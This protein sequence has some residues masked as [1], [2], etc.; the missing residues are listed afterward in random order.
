MIGRERHRSEALVIPAQQMFC[1]RA[2]PLYHQHSCS[3]GGVETMPPASRLRDRERTLVVAA[4]DMTVRSHLRSHLY[5]RT[6]FTLQDNLDVFALMRCNSNH[7]YF[8]PVSAGYPS[9]TASLTN[10][11]TRTFVLLL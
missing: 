6:Q 10:L 5:R 7:T 9:S 3:A 1:H 11:F 8:P 4:M 2:I